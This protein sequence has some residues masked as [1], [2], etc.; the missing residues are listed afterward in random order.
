MANKF[1]STRRVVQREKRIVHG[2]YMDVH[3]YPVFAK[4]KY[5]RKKCK[6]SSDVQK[7]LNQ[8]YREEKLTW[9]INTNFTERD[10]EVGLGFDD[11]HLPETY[12]GVQ[13]AIRNFIRRLKREREKNNLA[14]LK[15]IYVIERGE[16]KGRFHAHMIMNGDMDRDTIEKLWR[17]GYAHT[18]RLKFDDEGLRGLAKYKLK[19]PEENSIDGKIRR[20]AASKNLK[21]PTEL[22]ERDGYISRKTT[23]EIFNGNITEKEIERL[24]KGYEV[25]K[26]NPFFNDVNCGYYCTI[27]LK[28]KAE[29]I[30]EREMKANERYKSS[31]YKSSNRE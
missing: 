17:Q 31:N 30:K 20:W 6:A 12:E 25:V 1:K 14:E 22:K 26:V 13:K 24:Y 19:E 21:K 15:Y 10:L 28:L 3:I 7:R 16:K 9:L 4:P 27:R 8:K 18:F 23:K 2:N 5:R 11:K 29:K